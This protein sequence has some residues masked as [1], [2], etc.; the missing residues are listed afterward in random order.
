MCAIRACMQ[1]GP[2]Y[3]PCLLG[4]VVVWVGGGGW[5]GSP[6]RRACSKYLGATYNACCVGWLVGRGWVGGMSQRITAH[7]SSRKGRPRECAWAHLLQFATTE[8]SSCDCPRKSHGFQINAIRAPFITGW[9][10]VPT[11]TSEFPSGVGGRNVVVSKQCNSRAMTGWCR[12][13]R[14]NSPRTS[15]MKGQ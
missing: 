2:R 10:R 4:W 12:C 13:A 9:C 11:R 5:A 7:N 14:Q 1:I 8:R 3:I 15:R 6:Q